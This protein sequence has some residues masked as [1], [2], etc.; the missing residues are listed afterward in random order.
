MTSIN[1]LPPNIWFRPLDHDVNNEALTTSDRWRMQTVSEDKIK[2][3]W[4]QEAVNL[5]LNISEQIYARNKNPR[6][7]NGD[8]NYTTKVHKY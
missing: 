3:Q 2:P 6:I 7:V 8:H 1:R 5:M 4:Q